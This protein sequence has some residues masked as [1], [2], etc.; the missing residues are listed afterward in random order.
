M[1]V[2]FGEIEVTTAPQA[3]PPPPQGG[4]KAEQTPAD[5]AREIDKVLHKQ[6]QRGRR[7]WAY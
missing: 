1:A 6:M 3:P 2:V 7:L 4:G 5:V